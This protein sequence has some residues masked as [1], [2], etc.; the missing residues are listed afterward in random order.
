LKVAVNKVTLLPVKTSLDLP[1]DLYR[2]VKSKSAL[3][4]LA[5]R[6]V[7]T[8]LFAAWV[9]GRVPHHV[10][11]R[12]SGEGEPGVPAPHEAWLDQWRSL[13][14]RLADAPKSGSLVQQLRDDRR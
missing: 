7:A 2:R 3:E 4:G 6:E 9:E 1:D 10:V 13:A 8:A 14:E 5:V 12:L 11:A